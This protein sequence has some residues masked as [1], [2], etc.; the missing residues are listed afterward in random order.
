MMPIVEI[1]SDH[2]GI[3]KSL[4]APWEAGYGRRESLHR[5]A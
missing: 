2:A 3:G 5:S 4:Q 1:I